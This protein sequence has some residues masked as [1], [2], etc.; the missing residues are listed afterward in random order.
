MQTSSQGT[1]MDDGQ[2]MGIGVGVGIGDGKID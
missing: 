1:Q 2:V